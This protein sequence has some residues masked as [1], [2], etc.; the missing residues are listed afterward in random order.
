MKEEVVA[1]VAAGVIAGASPVLLLLLHVHIVLPGARA[2]QI[3][4]VPLRGFPGEGVA[5]GVG[6]GAGQE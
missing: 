5:V 1:G 2:Q 6:A 3:S 4:A